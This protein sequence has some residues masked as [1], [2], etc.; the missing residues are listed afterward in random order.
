M[1]SCLR[2]QRTFVVQTNAFLEA[3]YD[4]LLLTADHFR[5]W[6]PRDTELPET[7]VAQQQG[8]GPAQVNQV[9]E[10]MGKEKSRLER[11]GPPGLPK[12]NETSAIERIQSLA[13][14]ERARQI[15]LGHVDVW[16]RSVLVHV[17]VLDRCKVCPV[18]PFWIVDDCCQEKR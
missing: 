8:E 15:D 2:P 5:T 1:G 10:G 16:A 4:L 9:G 14:Q 6:L 12:D 13:V 3:E 7:G 11:A 17:V 18:E